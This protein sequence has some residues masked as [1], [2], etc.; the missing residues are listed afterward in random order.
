M[1]PHSLWTNY[2]KE[3][4]RI[5]YPISSVLL[6]VLSECCSYHRPP[7]LFFNAH[8][9]CCQE[10]ACWQYH[11]IQLYSELWFGISFSGHNFFR[12]T[13]ADVTSRVKY[14]WTVIVHT[15]L[16]LTLSWVEPAACILGPS[17]L[18]Y[19]QT[20]VAIAVNMFV[21]KSL[22]HVID[23]VMVVGDWK[24]LRLITCSTK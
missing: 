15:W 22:T 12:F 3:I 4:R 1:Y 16:S 11:S 14:I 10:Q 7:S 6:I 8:L 19:A 2:V 23:I 24:C 13:A 20:C 9:L 5:W 18:P 21:H 17:C